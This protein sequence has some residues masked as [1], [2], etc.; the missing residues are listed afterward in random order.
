MK[1]LLFLYAALLPNI[2]SAQV[3]NLKCWTNFPDLKPTTQREYNASVEFLDDGAI[4]TIDD[5]KI[6]LKQEYDAPV[7]F[8]SEDPWYNLQIG[9]RKYLTKYALGVP[10]DEDFALYLNCEEVQ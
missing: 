1:K 3:V 6:T 10:S 5:K 4:L 9:N 8:Y 7:V 2:V